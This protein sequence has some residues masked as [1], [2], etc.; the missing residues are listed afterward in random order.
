MD[1]ALR[2]LEAMLV[3]ADS[4]HTL[5]VSG[6]G[7]VIQPTDGIVAIG[8]GGNYSLAAARALVAHTSL[9]AVEVVQQ[10]LEIAASIDV[11]TNAH[12][13]VEQLKSEV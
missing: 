3:V 9:S 1:R 5:L 11:Y 12:I 13:M 7:D 4:H 8:S 10:A 6:T 2:R